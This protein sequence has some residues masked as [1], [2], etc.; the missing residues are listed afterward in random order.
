[1]LLRHHIEFSKEYMMNKKM[2]S[3]ILGATMIMALPII[4][5]C[6]SNTIGYVDS[7]KVVTQTAKSIEINKE[8]NAKGKELQAKVDAADEASKAQ[9][10]TDAKQDFTAFTTAKNQELKQYIDQQVNELAKEKKL[11]V[12]LL[13]G[14]VVG[15][16]VD[17]LINKMGKASD[18]D[19]KAAE[20]EA[21]Q[22]EAQQAQQAQQGEAQTA[23][24]TE[25]GAAQ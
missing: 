21:N 14:A 2:K 23:Q 8:I 13:K 24:S 9:V 12:V 6:G 3:L 20:N 7:Q 22:Q 4:G 16:G 18:E 5:G 17:D 10:M 19:I 15:G 25:A 11:D 1:M